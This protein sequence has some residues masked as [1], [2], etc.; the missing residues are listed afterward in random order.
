M[1][2]PPRVVFIDETEVE[3]GTPPEDQLRPYRLSRACRMWV[4][5]DLLGEAAGLPQNME[6][7]LPKRRLPDQR[8]SLLIGRHIKTHP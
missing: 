7:G 6:T 8:D 4:N 2:F 5:H 1:V 3:E